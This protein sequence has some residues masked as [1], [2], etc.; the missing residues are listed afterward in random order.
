MRTYVAADRFV[1]AQLWWVAS[2]LVR[3]HSRLRL[4]EFEHDEIGTYIEVLSW[5]DTAELRMRFSR[6]TGV[7]IRGRDEFRIS[8]AEVLAAAN[9]HAIMERF[10]AGH[11]HRGGDGNP[12]TH[13]LT[14]EAA[15]PLDGT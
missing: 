6:V 4:Q 11:R 9:P 10:E 14:K 15:T 12:R 7:Q 8:P 5:P 2:E 3:R 13:R 1:D